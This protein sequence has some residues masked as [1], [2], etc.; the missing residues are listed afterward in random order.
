MAASGGK[1]VV[2]DVDTGGGQGT[3]ELIHRGGGEAQFVRADVTDYDD[4]TALMETAVDS[5]GRLDVLHNNAGIHESSLSAHTSVDE[6][7]DEL[8]DLVLNVNLKSV[9]RCSRRAARYMREQGGGS[10]VN[11]GSTS[12]FVG[13]PDGPAYCASKGAIV[14]L[15]KCMALEWAADGIRVNCYCPAS[16]DTGMVAAYRGRA[17]SREDIDR[18]LVGSHLVGRLG[19]PEEVANL[20]CFLAS[21]EA[22]FM[23]GGAYLIDGGSLAWRGVFES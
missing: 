5:F 19:D 15:T 20:V 13:Y 2:S 1:V 3:V 16:I 4:I 22:S 10:I 6:I 11:A 7:S 18:M 23:T 14:Q 21:D 8:W 17:S 12:S 9:L